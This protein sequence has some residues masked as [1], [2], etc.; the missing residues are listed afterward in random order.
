MFSGKTIGLIALHTGGLRPKRPSAAPSAPTAADKSK[1]IRFD[2]FLSHKRSDAQDT[3]ARTH[4]NRKIKYVIHAVQCT[5]Y[6]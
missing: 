2:A 3:V 6:V 1:S 4:A 5:R